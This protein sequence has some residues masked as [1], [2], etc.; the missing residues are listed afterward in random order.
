[1]PVTKRRAAAVGADAHDGDGRLLAARAG[2]GGVDHAGAADG[3][4]GDGVQ[5]VVELAGDANISGVGRTGRAADLNEAA[6]GI[7]GDAEGEAR[8]P[9]HEHV[10]RL[11]IDDDDGRAKAIRAEM[12]CR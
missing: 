8:G 9:A 11:A 5:A 2:D 12:R 10:C 1:M 6:R 3:G 4:A 7:A